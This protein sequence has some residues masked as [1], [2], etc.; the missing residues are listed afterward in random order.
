VPWI[1]SLE[2]KLQWRKKRERGGGHEI[3]EGKEGDKL[4][5]EVCLTRLSF[6]KVTTSVTY[7]SQHALLRASKARL[8]GALSKGGKMRGVAT[9]VYLW[10]TSEK[11][12]GNRSK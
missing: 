9:N 4:N 8:T 11:T 6:I 2:R 12:E 1:R 3:E 7:V 10:E 5:F